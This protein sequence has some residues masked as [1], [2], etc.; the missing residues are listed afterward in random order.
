MSALSHS[1]SHMTYKL[2]CYS[3]TSQY[4]GIYGII[5]ALFP[6]HQPYLLVFAR[7]QL[8]MNKF[9]YVLFGGFFLVTRFG[10]R[11]RVWHKTQADSVKLFKSILY[12]IIH[13]FKYLDKW[14][15]PGLALFGCSVPGLFM[16]FVGSMGYTVAFC[17]SFRAENCLVEVCCT[18]YRN[19][20]L[21]A[22]QLTHGMHLTSTEKSTLCN[23]MECVTQ[24]SCAITR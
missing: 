8:L 9:D 20:R 2:Y 13:S 4:H 17:C 22:T 6:T 18:V 23:R 12:H 15:R 7:T 10:T 16:G 21:R 1:H 5:G 14:I 11:A 24:A 19:A 3:S